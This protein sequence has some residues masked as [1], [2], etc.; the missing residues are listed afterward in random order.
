MSVRFSIDDQS[1]DEKYDDDKEEGEE[2]QEWVGLDGSCVWERELS[3]KCWELFPV[4][5]GGAS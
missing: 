5:G 4:F 2:I 3:V 1:K